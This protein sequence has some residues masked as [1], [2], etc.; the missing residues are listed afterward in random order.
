M[1]VYVIFHIVIDSNWLEISSQ[2]QKLSCNLVTEGKLLITMLMHIHPEMCVMCSVTVVII[3]W[4]GLCFEIHW[5]KLWT[6][7]PRMQ[8][9]LRFSLP[10]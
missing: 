5:C 8:C 10:S 3:C 4:L 2:V 7:S 9:G 1:L 6:G